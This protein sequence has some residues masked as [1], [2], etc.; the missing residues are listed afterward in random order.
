[1]VPRPARAALA[2]AETPPR[3]SNRATAAPTKRQ[4]RSPSTGRNC[5]NNS[6]KRSL[7]IVFMDHIIAH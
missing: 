6:L 4:S 2:T 5:V 3:P 1:M 7:A